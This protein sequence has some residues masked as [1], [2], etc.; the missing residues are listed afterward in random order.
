MAGGRGPCD[1]EAPRGGLWVWPPI[2]HR[3]LTKGKA[4]GDGVVGC[5]LPDGAL[6]AGAV[7]IAE[8]P[9]ARPSVHRVLGQVSSFCPDVSLFRPNVSTF[10]GRSPQMCPL[11][12]GMCPLCPLTEDLSWPGPRLS[13]LPFRDVCVTAGVVARKTP[14]PALSPRRG[15]KTG[16]VLT[17]LTAHT[18]ACRGE[19]EEERPQFGG[20]GLLAAAQWDVAAFFEVQ[21]VELAAQVGAVGLADVSQVRAVPLPGRIVLRRQRHR[22]PVER[23]DFRVR[24]LC[25]SRREPGPHVLVAGPR[26]NRV[27]E[28]LRVD[29]QELEELAGEMRARVV[30][31]Q[32]AGNLGARLVDGSR[33][34]HDP[35]HGLV[36]TARYSVH[37]VHRVPPSKG[38]LRIVRAERR[39][40]AA[41]DPG[42]GN[43]G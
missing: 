42:K 6:G 2:V 28:V 38:D 25:H 33:Q 27:D 32:G 29:S 20:R 34:E 24:P 11:G 37:Q 41:A 23:G 22:C 36:R 15:I 14:H 4:G 16:D 7:W 26:R 8:L 19:W 39:Q 43:G 21:A 3:V 17:S 1:R 10:R 13:Y 18:V 5:G 35:M 40:E 31:P 9:L 30:V 12:L